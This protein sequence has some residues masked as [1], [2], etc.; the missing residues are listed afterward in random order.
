MLN[1]CY[2]G[3][4]EL[5]VGFSLIG[6]KTHVSPVETKALHRLLEDECRVRDLIILSSTCAKRLGKRVEELMVENPLPPIMVLPDEDSAG[7]DFQQPI[8]KM[9]LGATFAVRWAPVYGKI[10][11]IGERVLNFDFY[12][13]AG[14]GLLSEQK[15][16]AVYDDNAG[17][18]QVP[19]T[20]TEAGNEALVPVN[21]GLGFDFF[22]TQSVALKI[23]ARSSF[24]VDDKP[25]YDPEE[26]VTEKRLNNNF[27]ASVGLAVFF[28]R[29]A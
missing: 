2:I 22:I 3:D 24:Y 7:V 21:V 10:N 9:I 29:F 13:V 16:Y 17:D 27:T 11:L 5:A 1:V 19:V 4:D 8:D 28:P 23:D 12:G 20:L 25:Q 18:G 6:V 15:Y 26:P 14:L